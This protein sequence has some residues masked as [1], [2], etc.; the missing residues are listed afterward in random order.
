MSQTKV[1]PSTYVFQLAASLMLGGRE[2]R[3]G[4]GDEGRHR[5]TKQPDV[6]RGN[7]HHKMGYATCN[8]AKRPFK[9][10]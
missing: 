1:N 4:G 8:F 6:G 5:N 10:I 2:G 3:E 7:Y 9:G